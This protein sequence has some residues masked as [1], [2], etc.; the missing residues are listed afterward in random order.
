MGD[1]PQMVGGLKTLGEHLHQC[2][3]PASLGGGARRAEGVQGDYPQTP[4]QTLKP[5]SAPALD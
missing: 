5:S 1:F 4:L 3:P 2:P